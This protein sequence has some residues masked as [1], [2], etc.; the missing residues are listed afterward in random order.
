MVSDVADVIGVHRFQPQR[1]HGCLQN[2]QKRF[3]E[4]IVHGIP[5]LFSFRRGAPLAFQAEIDINPSAS[6]PRV[7]SRDASL[8][9]A[10]MSPSAHV[11][12][13][14]RDDSNLFD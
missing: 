6:G 7:S 14:N 11:F 5:V 10:A 13:V 2:L 9:C 3:N 1:A 8:K 4:A 12:P